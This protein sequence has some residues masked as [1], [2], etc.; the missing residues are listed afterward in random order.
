MCSNVMIKECSI[1]LLRRCSRC[2][3]VNENKMFSDLWWDDFL[4]AMS[5]VVHY[6]LRQLGLEPYSWAIFKHS[7]KARAELR[8]VERNETLDRAMEYKA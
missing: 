8:N 7:V 5:R 2:Q 4:Q 6:S 3:D 1:P